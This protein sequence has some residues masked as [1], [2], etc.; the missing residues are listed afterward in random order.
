MGADFLCSV[1]PIV[2]TRDQALAQLTLL[3][4]ETVAQR[5]SEVTGEDIDWQDAN[6][7]AFAVNLFR[8]CINAVYDEVDSYGRE[9]CVYHLDGKVLL[10]TGGMSWG[11]S[12][13]ELFDSMAAIEP[14]ALTE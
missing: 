8:G 10:I 12:P 5:Y 9:A 11:D 6:E 7:L 4:P 2:K 13:T 3:S 14:L 1:L